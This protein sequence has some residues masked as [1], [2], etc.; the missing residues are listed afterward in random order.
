MTDRLPKKK[1]TISVEGETEMWY[2]DW[3]ERQ[4]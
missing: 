4:S 2:F 1:Y 3:L